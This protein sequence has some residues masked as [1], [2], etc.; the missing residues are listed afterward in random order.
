MKSYPIS[1]V[2]R[3]TFVLAKD[4][5]KIGNKRHIDVVFFTSDIFI[6]NII[7]TNK[8]TSPYLHL[9]S[10]VV[11]SPRHCWLTKVR[12]E[13]SLVISKIFVEKQDSHGPLGVQSIDI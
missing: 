8:G 12:D 1:S 5:C 10:F 3:P 2:A 7:D 6:I 4:I 11:I 13:G 9:L